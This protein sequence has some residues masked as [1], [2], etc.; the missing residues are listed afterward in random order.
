LRIQIQILYGTRFIGYRLETVET[1]NSLIINL[2]IAVCC[3]IIL[4]T[5]YTVY[6]YGVLIGFFIE[7]EY[8][9]HVPT[10]VFIIYTVI[11]KQMFSKN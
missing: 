3:F 4:Y 9:F 5:I 6:F 8:W 7:R 1:H 10:S 2:Y 11:Y